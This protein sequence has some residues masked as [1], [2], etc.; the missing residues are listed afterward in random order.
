MAPMISR[1][2]SIENLLQGH[3]KSQ[4]AAVRILVKKTF[5]PFAQAHIAVVKGK[6][7]H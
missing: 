5:E 7:S 1:Q 3:S 2:G 4:P 6:Y